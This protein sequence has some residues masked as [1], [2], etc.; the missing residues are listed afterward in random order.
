[1]NK[2]IAA[3]KRNTILIMIGFVLFITL[4]GALIAY[5]MNSFGVAIGIFIAAAAYAAFQYFFASQIAVAMT[6]A[7]KITKQDQPRLFAAVEEVA[8]TANLPIPEIYLINDPAP[9]AFASGRDPKHAL[10]AVTTGLLDVMETAELK[11]VIAH[12]ISHIKNYDIRLSMINF[13]LACI[14][15]FIS[16]LGFRMLF[17]GDRRRSGERSPVGVGILFFVS[18]L[19]PFVA[20]LAQLAI[21]REREYL[22]DASSAKLT[23]RP[24]SMI[25]ALKKL[26]I[27]AQPMKRQNLAAEAMF[28]NNPLRSN[29][30]NDLFN[31]HPSI[32]QRIKRLEHGD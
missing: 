26:D 27:H 7:Q 22:A 15:G 9:N 20:S 29:K 8:T 24:D 31:T 12:E 32:E 4:L 5:L 21:S 11:A 14:V 1:M 19:A 10:V 17:Y 3:N 2:Q 30:L 16:D 25:A 6:G 23:K 13:G 28:I 18:L